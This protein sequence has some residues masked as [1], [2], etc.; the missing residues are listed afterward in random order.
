MNMYSGID[1]F[2]S[3]RVWILMADLV[4]RKVAHQKTDKHKSTTVES[5]AYMPNYNLISNWLT[6]ACGVFACS[7]SFS[8]KSLNIRQS[9][10]SL[11]REIVDL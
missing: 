10:V 5:N 6:S 7:M 11:A 8:A 1:V 2:R 9:L 4:V 3:S